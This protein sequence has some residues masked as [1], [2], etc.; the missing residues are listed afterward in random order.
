MLP[1]IISIQI[2]HMLHLE[3]KL[4]ESRGCLVLV[5]K[6][7]IGSSEFTIFKMTKGCSVWSIKYI[8]DTDDFMTPLPEG[9]SIRYIVWSLVVGEREEDSIL[10]MNLS[11]KVVQYNL[12]S[13]TV[14]ED[15]DINDSDLLLTIALRPCNRNHQLRDTTRTTPTPVSLSQTPAF[16]YCAVTVKIIS[17]LAGIVQAV[18]RLKRSYIREGGQ[19]DVVPTQ[20][21]IRKLIEDVGDD[22][23]FTRDMWVSAVEY[24]NV[25]GGIVSGSFGD[26]ETNCQNGKLANVVVVTKSCTPN[27][28][29]DITVSLKDLSGSISRASHYKVL[30]EGGYVKVITFGAALILRNVFMFFAKPSAHYLNITLRNMVMVFPKDSITRNASGVGGSVIVGVTKE[31]VS[32]RVG[33][34]T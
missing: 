32:T 8:V 23:D 31:E 21:Y 13:K 27:V 10:V 28:L 26:M 29:G 33:E 22:D 34:G 4:F 18:K 12:I 7:Y 3:R 17:G 19:E 11:G 24:V 1:M 15:F 20:E 25:E 16:A 5:R 30:A 14:I 6:D 9:W 2:P